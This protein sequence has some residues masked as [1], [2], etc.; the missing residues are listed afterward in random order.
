[1]AH[2]IAIEGIDGSGK[3]TQSKRLVETLRE[4]G[5]RVGFMG[6]PRYSETFFGAR[7]GD[8]LNGRF[9]ELWDLPPFLIS[10][11]FAGDRLE[12]R[13]RLLE[14]LESHDLVIL[15]RYVGSNMA[16][17]SAR[18]SDAERREVQDWIEQ[19]EFDIHKMPRPSLNILLDL[20]V[21]TAQ[22]LVLKK[23][24]RDYT[25]QAADLQEADATYLGK[26][27]ETYRDL[28]NRSANWEVISV[29]G[30]SGIRSIEAVAADIL[31][32]TKNSLG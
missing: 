16:H 17:Q 21:A 10:L 12:S 5:Y 24:A 27:R 9:G 1:M 22:E 31:A 3:G 4:S 18:C 14:E 23:A 32:A 19:V 29:A 7:V 30:D 20:P 25:D 8:F 26:V 28:A 2:L 11:L 13:S 6:F 15:D